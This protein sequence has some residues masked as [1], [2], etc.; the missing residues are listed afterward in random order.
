MS[1]ARTI[2][3][4]TAS[5]EEIRAKLEDADLPSLLPTL[6]YITGDLSLLRPELRI[7]PALIAEPE[8]AG[9]TPEQQAAIRDL[10]AEVLGRFRDGGATTVDDDADLQTIVEF[11]AGGVPMDEYMVMLVRGARP[12]RQRPARP[13]VDQGRAGRRPAVPRRHRRLG[14]E[15]DH[16]RLPA[17]AGRGSTSRSSRR[18]T[19]SAARGRRTPTRA[20]GWTS[21]TTTTGTRSPSATTGRTSTHRGPSCTPTSAAASTSSASVTTSC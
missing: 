11:L 6:A 9:L 13:A 10:A 3:P 2:P 20:A 17:E 4:I 1:L 15:R 12:A 21:P 14:D 5:N 8:Q 19:T 7:D 16:R 18:T